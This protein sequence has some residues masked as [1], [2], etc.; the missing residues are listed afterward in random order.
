MRGLQQWSARKTDSA[1][2]LTEVVRQ[3]SAGP[4]LAALPL[5]Q[6]LVIMLAAKLTPCEHDNF[7]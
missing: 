4:S 2:D 7:R 1:K 3:A 5:G 6:F